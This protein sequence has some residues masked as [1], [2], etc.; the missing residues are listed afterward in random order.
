MKTIGIFLVCIILAFA[1]FA[2]AR[3]HYVDKHSVSVSNPFKKSQSTTFSFGQDLFG[4]WVKDEWVFAI[5]VPAVLIV[6]GLVL[7][8][9]K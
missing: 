7:S 8:A 2:Y 3:H 6:G 5:A 4:D 9:R 1:S